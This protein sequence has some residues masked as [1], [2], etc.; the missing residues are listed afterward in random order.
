[1]A[2]AAPALGGAYRGRR[3]RGMDEG[4]GRGGLS[5]PNPKIWPDPLIPLNLY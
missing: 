5:I 2:C 3:H 4:R 1:M